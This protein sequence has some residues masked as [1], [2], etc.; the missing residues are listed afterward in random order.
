MKIYVS[1]W[2]NNLLR[3]NFHP[4]HQA[5]TQASNLP[6]MNSILIYSILIGALYVSCS[7][8]SEICP[9]IHK[10]SQITMVTNT[11]TR[12]FSDVVM[13]QHVI[14]YCGAEEK[15]YG[16]DM[17]TNMVQEWI[18]ANPNKPVYHTIW[19]T[20]TLDSLI[21]LYAVHAFFGLLGYL[22]WSAVQDEMEK[23]N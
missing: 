19:G 6:I 3:L 7:F 5:R 16:N 11:Q 8:T 14:G 23:H 4:S 13:N 12:P 21:L 1:G 17:S 22:I 9:A 10:G 2:L 18:K 20:K 15:I